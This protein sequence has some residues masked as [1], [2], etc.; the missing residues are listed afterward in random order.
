MAITVTIHYS[1]SAMWDPEG[2]EGYD[3]LASYRKFEELV[4]RGVRELSTEWAIE[5]EN[6]DDDAV[7]VSC[8]TIDEAARDYEIKLGVLDIIG[9]VYNAWDWAVDAE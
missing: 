2:A 6:D 8:D 1:D 4:T 5:F 7:Y 3:V 9:N